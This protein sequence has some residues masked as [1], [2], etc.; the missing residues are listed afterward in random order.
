MASA[1]A[2]ILAYGFMQMNGLAGLTGWRWIFIMQG[3]VRL[4]QR[5]VGVNTTNIIVDH[6]PG[7]HRGIFLT[8]RFP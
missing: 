1:F 8:C 5:L 6:L 3:V 4:P 2:S 7:W